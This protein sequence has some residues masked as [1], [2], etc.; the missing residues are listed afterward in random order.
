MD[1]DLD[2]GVQPRCEICGTV[3]H[4]IDGG[5]QCRCCGHVVDIPWAE[6]PRDGDGLPGVGG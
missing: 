6:R 1:D 5:Y 2:A 4:V 3:M